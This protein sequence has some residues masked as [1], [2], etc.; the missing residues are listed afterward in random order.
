MKKSVWEP[1][2]LA[3]AFAVAANAFT[4]SGKVSDEQ[5]AAVSGASV[6]LVKNG[7]S[8]TTDSKGEFSFHK[9]LTGVGVMERILPGYISV[10]NGVL[11]FSQRSSEPVQVQIFDM[12]G[13]RLLSETLYGSGSLDLQ[14]CVKAQGAYYA[15]VKI[16]SAQRDIRFTSK[17]NYS[18]SFGDKSA[19]VDRALKRLTTNENLKVIA[20]GFDTLSVILSNL[21]TNVALTVKKPKAEPQYAYGWGLKNDPVPTRGCGKTWNRVKS[22]S[23]EFQWSKGKRTIRIDIPDNRTSSYSACTAW[24][25]GPVV[26]S[27]KATMV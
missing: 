12:M 4:L 20:D 26:C 8:T 17:G 27:K 23:Y 1:L 22:G 13:N 24:A 21:D 15:R 10:N 19:S 11:S 9:D 3:C 18:S 14:A 25:A 2:A 6:L 5:G 7:L 16:G